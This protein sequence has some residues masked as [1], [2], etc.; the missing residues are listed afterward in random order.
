M[1]TRTGALPTGT[2][3]LLQ[4]ATVTFWVADDFDPITSQDA[5]VRL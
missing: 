2:A 1:C 5:R 4:M 3:G